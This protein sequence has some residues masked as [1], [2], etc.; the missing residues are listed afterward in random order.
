MSLVIADIANRPLRSMVALAAR[1]AK[2]VRPL[3]LADGGAQYYRDHM[4]ELMVLDAFVSAAENYASTLNMEFSSDLYP[5]IPEWV[6]R[7]L[8]RAATTEDKRV[9][10]A[11]KTCTSAYLAAI[12]A[13]HGDIKETGI[14][15]SRAFSFAGDAADGLPRLMTA[16][17]INEGFGEDIKHLPIAKSP[18]PNN[19]QG[20]PVDPREDGPLGTLWPN[21]APEWYLGRASVVHAEQLEDFLT[22]ES[23]IDA[24]T[25]VTSI[26]EPSPI[27]VYLDPGESPQELISEFFLTLSAYYESLGGS[28]LQIVRDEQRSLVVEEASL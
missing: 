7:I 3:I 5:G 16:Q 21:G 28:G 23:V 1:C 19:E 26:P 13:S 12:A 8:D 6:S 20:D 22:L 4:D 10:A 18:W 14:S 17:S 11:V 9:H 27:S 15:A 25:P 2:R 24:L